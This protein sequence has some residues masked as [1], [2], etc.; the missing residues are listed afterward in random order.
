MGDSRQV[1][2]L[3]ND[4]SGI[5]MESKNVQNYVYSIVLFFEHNLLFT[6]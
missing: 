5:S 2:K 1:N 4:I 3:L 6:N